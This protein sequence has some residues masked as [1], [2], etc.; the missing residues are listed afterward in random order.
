MPQ[1]P[2]YD[3]V[4]AGAGPAGAMAALQ[5]AKAGRRVV[6]LEKMRWPREK[7]CGDCLN[8]SAWAIWQRHGLEEEFRALPQHVNHGVCLERDGR[9]VFRQQFRQQS[10]WGARAVRRDILDAWLIGKA[11]EAGATFVPEVTV[12]G[13][14]TETGLVET[15]EADYHGRIVLGADGR[16]STVARMAGLMPQNAGR[17]G[18]VA[19]QAKLSSALVDDF[20]HMNIFPEGYWGIARVD[21]TTANLCMVLGKGSKAAPQTMLARYFPGVLPCSWR[22][23]TP[24]T[25]AASALG[26]GRVWLA[27][28]AVRMVEPFTGEGIYFGLATGE[29]AGQCLVK[30]L[31]DLDQKA[32]SD[33]RLLSARLTDYRRQHSRLYGVRVRVNDFVHW[34]ARSPAVAMRAVGMLAAV[35]GVLPSLVR[36]VHPPDYEEVRT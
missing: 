27:G 28:D 7:V 20:V 23:V 36:W 2:L 5:L 35:P 11:V 13:V 31:D 33:S 6:I 3:V 8:P 10:R 24:I 25:R 4:V 32:K 18:R 22:S 15:T 26:K 12:T 29:L 21:D 14:D 9:E 1:L 30:A 19:W 17:C 34:C 16:N